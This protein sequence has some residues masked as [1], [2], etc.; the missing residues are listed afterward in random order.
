[1]KLLHFA[2]VGGLGF[3]FVSSQQKQTCTSLN[4]RGTFGCSSH[5]TIDEGK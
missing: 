5:H 1:M 2:G 4:H 3:A